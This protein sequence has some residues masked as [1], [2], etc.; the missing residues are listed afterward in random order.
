MV[1]A[2]CWL[3]FC[4]RPLKP[5]GARYRFRSPLPWEETGRGRVPA[6]F[7]L[8]RDWLAPPRPPQPRRRAR[9]PGRRAGSSISTA[10]G[11]AMSANGATATG[12]TVQRPRRGEGRRGRR[13]REHRAGSGRGTPGWV[14]REVPGSRASVELEAPGHP[15]EAGLR[16]HRGERWRPWGWRCRERWREMC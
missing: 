4:R 8:P 15:R 13:G 2:R 6:R 1:D 10:T 5:A 7:P 14:L 9:V 16:T 11:T 12:G 3:S